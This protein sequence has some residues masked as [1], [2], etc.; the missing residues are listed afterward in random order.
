MTLWSVLFCEK[1]LSSRVKFYNNILIMYYCACCK[2]LHFS[3]CFFNFT[4]SFCES[5]V[6]IKFCEA[7]WIKS[8]IIRQLAP[9]WWWQPCQGCLSKYK[10]TFL[11]TELFDSVPNKVC[12]LILWHPHCSWS[13]KCCLMLNHCGAPPCQNFHHFTKLIIS[14]FF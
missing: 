2:L 5:Q 8:I 12:I 3:W 9:W 7:W 1:I 6:D 14:F 10:F 13:W 4:T 11:L